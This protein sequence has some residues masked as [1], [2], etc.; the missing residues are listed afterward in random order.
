MRKLSELIASHGI[1]KTL[2]AIWASALLTYTIIKILGQQ[3]TVEVVAI[4]TGV[5]SV[6]I[7]VLGSINKQ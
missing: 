5:V 2:L 6:F 4:F 1:L 3:I 7:A